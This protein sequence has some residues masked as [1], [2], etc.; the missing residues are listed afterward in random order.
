MRLTPSATRDLMERHGI[1]PAKRLGQHFL[2]DP[3]VVDRIVRA[4][5]RQPGDPVLE[6]GAGLG[7]LTGALVDAGY[8]VTAY[9]VDSRLAPVLQEVVGDRARVIIGDAARIDWEAALDDRRWVMAANLPYNVGTPL[10]LD[11]LRHAPRL[12][13][14]VVM[15]QAEVVDRLTSRVG[16]EAYGLPSVVAGLHSVSRDRFGVPAQVFYPRPAVDSAVVVLDRIGADPRSEG[17]VELAARAFGQ[18]RKMLRSS[19]RGVL[20]DEDYAR[21]GVEATARPEELT[22]ADWLALVEEMP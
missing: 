14:F 11:A 10:L 19:L 9:E 12:V 21:A 5:D 22:P 20:S 6:I 4:I 18:R 1:R 17:A 8:E 16:D 13:R 7:T 15:L 2:I 3:N